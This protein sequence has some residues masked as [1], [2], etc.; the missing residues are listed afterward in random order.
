MG[1]NSQYF[2]LLTPYWFRSGVDWVR[3]GLCEEIAPVAV[4]WTVPMARCQGWSGECTSGRSRGGFSGKEWAAAQWAN[5]IRS[6]FSFRR[7]KN[8]RPSEKVGN[9][10]Q[11][12]AVQK[13]PVSD[14]F[15]VNLNSY[16]R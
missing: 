6:E 3:T 2:S 16:S 7:T 5:T 8:G 10:S 9:K 12:G 4:K 14:P 1:V 15:R 11:V 13:V